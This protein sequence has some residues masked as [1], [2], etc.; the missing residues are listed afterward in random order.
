MSLVGRGHITHQRLSAYKLP[1]S[2]V[3][4]GNMSKAQDRYGTCPHGTY[5]VAG[6]AVN[7][8]KL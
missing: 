3:G 1:E 7:N 5:V 4:L 8:F 2:V 6:N